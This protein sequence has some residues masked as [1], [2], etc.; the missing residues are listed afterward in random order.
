MKFKLLLFLNIIFKNSL[1]LK[2]K[3][4]IEYLKGYK[5]QKCNL[6]EHIK[7][8]AFFKNN[9]YKRYEINTWPHYAM[10]EYEFLINVNKFRELK[11]KWIELINYIK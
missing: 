3:L 2:Y 6:Y 11:I 9:N 1:K 7:Y 8:S 5:V 4:F 10:R